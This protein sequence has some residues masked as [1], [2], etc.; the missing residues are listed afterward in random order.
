MVTW[1]GFLLGLGAWAESGALISVGA[2][3]RYELLAGEIVLLP[4]ALTKKTQRLTT[5]AEE[6]E[7]V[8]VCF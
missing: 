7:V 4:V 3:W 8:E 1:L 5:A 2:W 6:E